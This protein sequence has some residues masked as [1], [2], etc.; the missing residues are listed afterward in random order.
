MREQIRHERYRVIV[1]TLLQVRIS[2]LKPERRLARRRL[3]RG[4]QNGNRLIVL[5][6]LL[7]KRCEKQDRRGLIRAI[8]EQRLEMADRLFVPLLAD[9]QPRQTE[10][11]AGRFRI[12]L[13]GPAERGRGLPILAVRQVQAAEERVEAGILVIPF[14]GRLCDLD[15]L[16]VPL[17]RQ[18]GADL[19]LE[20]IQRFRIGL[21]SRVE[22]PQRR[23]HVLLGDVQLPQGQPR[24]HKGRVHL[25]RPGKHLPRGLRIP[26]A[27]LDLTN[28]KIGLGKLRRQ[29]LGRACLGES[30][31][32]PPDQKERPPSFE[33]VG[34]RFVHRL[35][36]R[37]ELGQ[38][39]PRTPGS[40]VG[41][42]QAKA[43]RRA[44]APLS[45]QLLELS[46]G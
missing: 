23:V 5:A 22:F 37:I 41:F 2:E 35:P 6:D 4:L 3:E 18:E 45:F 13:E 29:P 43:N 32:E 39:I 19:R 40:V 42:G 15:G 20:S 10:K 8:L 11:G 7:V 12:E 24:R 26:S 31:V 44:V 30:F 46:G 36:E 34:R 38:A 28:K 21:D 1:A 16:F 25:C 9:R 17:L 27:N 33:M 14:D